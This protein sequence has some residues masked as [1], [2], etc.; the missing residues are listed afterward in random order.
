[1]SEGRVCAGR[2]SL[3]RKEG[4]FG[5][6]TEQEVLGRIE[7]F[8]AVDG[9][10]G[11]DERVFGRKEGSRCRERDCGGSAREERE[12]LDGGPRGPLNGARGPRPESSSTQTA[13]LRTVFCPPTDAPFLSFFA[14]FPC[15][16][17]HG[18]GWE[19]F[20]L[21]PGGSGLA[22]VT[23]ARR[24]SNRVTNS[25]PSVR[26][27]GKPSDTLDFTVSV[28]SWSSSVSSS[29]FHSYLFG[30][31]RFSLFVESQIHRHCLQATRRRKA[32]A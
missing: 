21:G 30:W 2:R 11:L 5:W 29:Q 12:D 23:F 7:G 18:R 31:F 3:C 4:F 13:R 32:L 27:R 17:A 26:A 20:R 14:P 8:R 6:L 1:V 19:E 9:G 10:S 28:L 24:R 16:S 15:S 25:H 22:T